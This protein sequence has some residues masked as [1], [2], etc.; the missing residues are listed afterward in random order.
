LPLQLE[1][2]LDAQVAAVVVV[3]GDGAALYGRC[4]GV[5]ALVLKL[6]EG[7]ELIISMC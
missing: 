6:L 7:L 2:V 1:V 4:Y 5:R 3:P